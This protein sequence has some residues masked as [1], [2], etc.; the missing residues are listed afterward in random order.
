MNERG[1]TAM[2]HSLQQ[3]THTKQKQKITHLKFNLFRMV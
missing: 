1:E 3:F 2:S